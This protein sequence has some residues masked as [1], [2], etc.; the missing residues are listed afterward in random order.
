[1]RRLAS[2]GPAGAQ[3]RSNADPRKWMQTDEN[4][5]CGF[6]YPI[7]SSAAESAATAGRCRRRA[8]PFGP[9]ACIRVEFT[10]QH[11]NN[12]ICAKSALD[13]GS[14]PVC[15]RDGAYDAFPS[16]EPKRAVVAATRSS[17]SGA[18]AVSTQRARDRREESRPAQV[19][20]P[21]S[22]RRA[23]NENGQLPKIQR[24]A[25]P[26]LRNLLFLGDLWVK[27]QRSRSL[28]ARKK[29]PGPAPAH[30]RPTPPQA[31]MPH[32]PPASICPL[33]RRRAHDTKDRRCVRPGVM[34][35]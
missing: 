5:V 18:I 29:Y 33:I 14:G 26:L 34:A 10:V 3:G 16:S 28:P 19:R 24:Q 1:M 17:H 4:S 20:Q 23:R 31:A 22:L 6:R 30:L 2:G 8:V 11:S 9:C 25:K 27:A 12:T 32:R 21:R 13:I 15:A 7:R 35:G